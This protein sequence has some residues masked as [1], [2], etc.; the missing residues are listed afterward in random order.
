MVRQ[1]AQGAARSG[2][3]AGAVLGLVP[4][5]PPEDPPDAP[6]MFGQFAVD[7]CAGGVDWVDGADDGAGLAAETTATPPPTSSNAEMAAV[8]TVRRTPVFLV[9]VGGASTVGGPAGT[10]G[11]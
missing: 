3:C 4:E 7:P 2:Y 8:N 5:E 11:W 10:R 9:S 1:P 6:P